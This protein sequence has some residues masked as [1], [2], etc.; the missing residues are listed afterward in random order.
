MPM[1]SLNI[2]FFVVLLVCA[3]FHV[4]TAT[5][6]NNRALPTCSAPEGAWQNELGSVLIIESL[7]PE[8]GMLKGTYQSASGAGATKF[9]LIGWAND[10]EPSKEAPCAGCKPNHAQVYGFTVRWG[11]IGSITSWTGTCALVND[12][13]TLKTVWNLARPNSGYDWDHVNAGSATFVPRKAANE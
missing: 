1:L 3:F 13:P 10:A 9:P 8:T 7:N 6:Q 12:Q 11:D 5:A 4:G 2:Q